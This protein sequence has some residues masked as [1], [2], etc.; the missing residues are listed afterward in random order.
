MTLDE[1]IKYF[2]TG[3]KLCKVLGIHKSNITGWRNKGYIPE[4]QQ[5]R[6]EQLTKGELKCD[7]WRDIQ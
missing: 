6:I 3:Y 4:L 1:A 2:G 7:F 5:R